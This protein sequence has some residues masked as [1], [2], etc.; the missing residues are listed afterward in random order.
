MKSLRRLAGD[1][2]RAAGPGAWAQRSY[3]Q[4]GED[5][6]VNRIIGNAGG[7]FYVDIGSHHPFRFSNTYLFY[8]KGW[9]G[10]CVDP[11][12]GSARLFKRWRPRDICV[13]MGVSS[14]R[15]TLNYYMFNEPALNTFDG[16]LAKARDGVGGY[17]VT[18]TRAIQ[19][20][21]L[22]AILDQYV[23]KNTRID[24]LTVDVEGLDLQVLKSNDWNRYRPRVITAECLGSTLTSLENDE[25]ARFMSQLGYVATAKTGQSVIFVGKE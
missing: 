16:D 13:E 1:L 5:L 2:R 19:T 12:P 18:E 17:R 23:P 6:V 4:E 7:G 11:L 9:R 22:S 10:L 25:T 3:S 8:G 15:S 14:D 21:S 24:F 20:D